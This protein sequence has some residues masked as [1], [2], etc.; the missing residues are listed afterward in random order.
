MRMRALAA[1]RAARTPESPLLFT[2]NAPGGRTSDLRDR[3]HHRHALSRDADREV[4][5][6]GASSH[7][8]REAER[9][10]M[11]RQCTRRAA[12]AATE[13]A[14]QIARGVANARWLAT[15]EQARDGAKTRPDAPAFDNVP[16][17]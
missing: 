13:L 7:V 10:C 3:K 5:I 2:R 1:M 4:C 6:R 16:T 15:A 14:P 11:G 17:R 12:V 8:A 9:F